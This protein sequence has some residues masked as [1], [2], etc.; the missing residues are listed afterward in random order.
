VLGAIQSERTVERIERAATVGG[1]VLRK[2]ETIV[3][4][5]FPGARVR[6]PLIVKLGAGDERTYMSEWFGPVAFIIET[7]DTNQSIEIAARIGREVGSIT[8]GVYATD[9]AVI[10]RA[11][12]ALACA[13]VPTSCNLTGSIWV[14]Q[15]A[16]FSD[17]HVS[18]GNPAGNAT[19]CDGAFVATRFRTVQSRV[20][21]R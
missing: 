8:C 10:D 19:L 12:D 17:F 20:L 3:N 14:N 15:S 4:E 11:V 9:E 21:V 7:E 5:R 1:E 13:G 16:A 6:S 2:S 18:G